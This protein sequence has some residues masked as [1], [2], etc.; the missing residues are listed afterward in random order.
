MGRGQLGERGG[1]HRLGPRERPRWVDEG[2]D[3]LLG[4]DGGVLDHITGARGGEALLREAGK[5]VVDALTRNAGEPR[6]LGGGRG[7]A[8]D[9]GDVGL[10]LVLRQ[11]EADQI[12]GDAALVHLRSV[13]PTVVSRKPCPVTGCYAGAKSVRSGSRSPR[14]T[15]RSTSTQRRPRASASVRACSTTFCAAST[16]RTPAMP[17]SGLIRSR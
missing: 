4:G 17:G 8:A 15:A 3:R 9:E 2:P 6:D 7:V 14:R 1:R 11:A 5:D 16:P 13:P 10:R 12:L